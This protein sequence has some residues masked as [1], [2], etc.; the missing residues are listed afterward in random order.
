M[1]LT[2][3]FS[4]RHRT[5]RRTV[6]EVFNLSE[7]EA[8]KGYPVELDAVV[9]FSDPEWGGLFVQDRTGATYIDVHGTSTRYP[10]GARI[11]AEAVTAMVNFERTFLQPK[12]TVIGHGTLPR[13]EQKSIAELDAGAAESHLVVTK[14]VMH[15]CNRDWGRVCFCIH[16]AKK[17]VRI[18][19]TPAGESGHAKSGGG[20]RAGSWRCRPLH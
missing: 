13:P 17:E 14:G 15:P 8:A 16:D 11:R 3:G 4:K 7:E 18:F 19:L 1:S 5:F 20:N 2:N 9:L 6:S 10:Q 12:I